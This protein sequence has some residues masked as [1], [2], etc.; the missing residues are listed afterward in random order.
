LPGNGTACLFPSLTHVLSIIV[1]QID[2]WQIVQKFTEF[3][4]R[5]EIFEPREIERVKAKAIRQALARKRS[6]SMN[7]ELEERSPQMGTW[8]QSIRAPKFR[9]P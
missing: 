7:S 2:G 5:Y 3:A 6:R 4:T 1:V 9:Q 8:A